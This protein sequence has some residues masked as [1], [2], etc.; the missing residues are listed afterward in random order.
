MVYYSE[1]EICLEFERIMG[2]DIET[3]NS[4][5]ELEKGN[6]RYMR[7]QFGGFL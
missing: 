3:H 6:Q 2:Y 7:K 5:G 1:I 4:P